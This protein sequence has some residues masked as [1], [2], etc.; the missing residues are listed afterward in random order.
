MQIERR[1][2]ERNAV[3]AEGEEEKKV[4]IREKLFLIN[5]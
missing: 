3:V 2:C 4:D 5:L 1:R